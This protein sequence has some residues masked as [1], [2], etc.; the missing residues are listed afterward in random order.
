MNPNSAIPLQRG[1][2]V[3][4]LSSP[5]QIL[6]CWLSSVGIHDPG[7]CASYFSHSPRFPPSHTQVTQFLWFPP[8]Q[9]PTISLERKKS[10]GP[11][12]RSRHRTRLQ[13]SA[14]SVRGTVSCETLAKV[15]SKVKP[16]VLTRVTKA[17]CRLKP[18]C[19]LDVTFG[20]LFY[21]MF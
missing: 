16:D 7:A 20:H 11:K 21:A 14:E 6:L 17:P 5:C 2:S 18:R 4:G 8:D 13:L 1:D 15:T 10:L 3:L 19:T 9:L 12:S